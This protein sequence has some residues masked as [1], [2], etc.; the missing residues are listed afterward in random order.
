MKTNNTDIVA[1]HVY[2]PEAWHNSAYVIGNPNGLK[3][4]RDAIDEA[5]EKGTAKRE[6][7]VASDGEGFYI[8]VGCLDEDWQSPRWAKMAVPYSSDVAKENREDVIHPWE[9]CPDEI[10][11]TS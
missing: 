5:L 10:A 2:G 9:I 1:L 11:G 7:I 6:C 3:A 8:R 4:L